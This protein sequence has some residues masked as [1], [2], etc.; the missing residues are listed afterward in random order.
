[1]KKNN[2]RLLLLPVFLMAMNC[3]SASR[4][5]KYIVSSPDNQTVLQLEVESS[6]QWSLTNASE[7]LL[8]PS[9]ISL[10]LADGTVLGKNPQIESIQKETAN[11]VLPAIN[12]RKKEIRD[13]YNQITINFKGDYG[14]IFRAYNDGIAYRFFSTKKGGITIADE[15]ANFNLNADHK[16]W[17]PYVRD[18][19]EGDKFQTPFE[20][21]YDQTNISQFHSD[22][23]AILPLL[24]DLGNQ[25]KALLME[26]DL[27]D[28]PGMYLGLNKQTKQGFKGVFPKCPVN[29]RVGGYENLN[30]WVSKRAD[31]IAKTTKSREF[32]WRIVFISKNDKELADNDMVQRLAAPSRIAD[33]SWIKPG[34]VAWDWWNNWNITHVDFRAGINTPTYKYYIDFASEYG[35]EYVVLDEGWYKGRDILTSSDEIDL[36]EILGYAKTKNVGIILWTA[37]HDLDKVKEQAFAKYAAIGVKG[38]KVDFF[39]RDDQK[40]MRS[41][42]DLAE[43]AAKNKMLLDY[44]G[45]KPS[46][47]QKT[48]PNVVNFE[49]VKGLENVK[50][51]R[52]NMPPYDVTLPFIRMMAGPMDYTPGAMRNATRDNFQP[53]NSM[54][55]SQG[56]RVHQMAMYVVFEAPLQMLCDNPTAYCRESECTHFI[57]KIPTVTDRTVILDAK[58][59]EYIV[60]ARSKNNNWFVGALTNWDART[61]TVD[62][63]FLPEGKYKAVIFNDGINADRDATDYKCEEKIL[64]NKDKL[65]IQLA[66]G[67]GWAA[68]FE[69][70]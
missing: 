24:V 10:H 35:L 63:S 58:V 17:I 40:S 16:A 28:Y 34:K 69:K 45:M 62:L 61:L 60:T 30:F 25:K 5:S 55:M 56:T 64:T 51:A 3:F 44:H 19:R 49:G 4:Q 18:P 7:T 67:G 11:N 6:I 38:F 66:P 52:D 65:V 47:I 68:R 43:I 53:S 9:A 46:G 32:P 22:S 20:I 59:S 31:F 50:W 33:A 29:E 23:L 42:Y 12:Y 1:M 36:K 27:E 48:W 39:D 26:T 2:P 54:P 21:I 8:T 15:E 13:N 14:L 57:A 41:C 70:K 37:W